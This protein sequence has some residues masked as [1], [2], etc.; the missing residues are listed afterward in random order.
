MA[1]VGVGV[2]MRYSVASLTWE[3]DCGLMA[4]P[5]YV[6]T[7]SAASLVAAAALPAVSLATAATC[8]GN[9]GGMGGGMGQH[10]WVPRGHAQGHTGPASAHTV[11]PGTRR[12]TTGPCRACAGAPCL[13]S[14]WRRHAR[15]RWPRRRPWP[16]S[17]SQGASPGGP[18]GRGGGGVE[19]CSGR[20]GDGRVCVCV[21]VARC[22]SSTTPPPPRARAL[23]VL[24]SRSSSKLSAVANASQPR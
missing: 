17:S 5:P 6:P 20:N 3:R 1:R 2:R 7:L 10:T 21:C 9:K 19:V 15:A 16:P 23:T 14:P 13:P 11:H 22:A 8:G 24:F 12:P 18:G 4:S